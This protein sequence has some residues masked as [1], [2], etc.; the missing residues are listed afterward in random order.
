MENPTDPQFSRRNIRDRS[1]ALLLVG[2]VMLLPPI[3]GVSLVD[4]D[5]GGLP[6]PLL[7]VF[8]IWALL[9]AGAAAIA[10]PLRDSDDTIPSVDPPDTDS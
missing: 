1:T 9:I 5:I 2:I 8:V 6:I 7:Y 3:A 10:R 4:G